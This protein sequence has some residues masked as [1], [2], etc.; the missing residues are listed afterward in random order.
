MK[1]GRYVLVLTV[2]L[3]IV[4]LATA[5]RGTMPQAVSPISG[6]TEATDFPEAIQDTG[7]TVVGLEDLP[8][9]EY[10]QREIEVMN[11]GQRIYGIAYIPNTGAETVP[12]VICAHGL[13]GSYQTNLAYAEQLASHGLAT[14]SFDFRGGGGSRSDGSTTEMSVMTEVSDL[15]VILDAAREWDFV[16]PQRIVL[17][18]TSQGGITSAIAAARRADDVAGAILMYP[19]FVVHDDIHKRFSSLDEVPEVFQFNWITAGRPYVE[20]MWDYDV[21]AEIGNYK[22]KVLLMH[23]SADGIVP[24]SYSDRAAEVYE[25][26]PSAAN[27]AGNTKTVEYREGLYVGYRYFETAKVPV[28]FPFGYGLSY[29][30]FAYSDLIA[31][32]HGASLYV[33]NIGS[34]AGSEI[35]QLYIS[36][37]DGVIF[38]PTKELKGFAKVKLQPGEKKR[39]TIELDDKAF[40]FWNTLSGKWEIEGG[41]YD[42]LIGSDVQDVRLK[43]TIHIKGT[44]T[45]YPYEDM[46]I[47]CYRVADVL[48]VS[49]AAFEALLGK[50][51]PK[52]ELKIDRN[53]TLGELNHARSPLGWLVWLILTALLEA[54]YKRGEPDLNVLFQYNMPLRALAKMTGGAI[55][56]GMVDGIVMELQGF[57][58]VGIIRVLYEFVKNAVLN[59][60][61]ERRLQKE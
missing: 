5:C 42:I 40:R 43:E 8:V 31:N 38:R 57:W 25:D 4:V 29:T 34:V 10:E 51:I 21:Y 20:D 23:G 53:L 7:S 26:V 50:Q 59:A 45:V 9:Y 12:L 48:H 11:N 55:S 32:E 24:V 58:I 60:Q 47:D 61:M 41:N 14:Y 44:A 17:L 13:G 36:K 16:D 3:G 37:T 49:D 28:Q 6:N 30:Q 46:D 15:E 39:V 56:M 33:E 27:F 1:A 2:L 18:G 22:D 19:A 54:S 35:V 52:S